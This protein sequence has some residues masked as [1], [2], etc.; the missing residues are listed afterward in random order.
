APA[1]HRRPPPRQGRR[2][3]HRALLPL[4]RALALH[5]PR[6][7]RLLPPP[8]KGQ[9]FRPTPANSPAVTTAISDIL[10][11]HP[12]PFRCIHLICTQSAYRN[13]LARWP[14]SR[15]QGRPGPRPRQPPVA[16][17][18]APPA[19]ALHHHRPHP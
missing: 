19:H 2:A 7:H 3:H 11:A 13:Q 5:A 12:G 1:Q 18:R 4:A 16:A 6:P 9:G 10:E 15:R 8:Q 17:R 14:A